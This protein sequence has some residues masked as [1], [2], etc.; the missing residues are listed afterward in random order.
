VSLCSLCDGTGRTKCPSCDGAATFVIERNQ[1]KDNL[2]CRKCEGTGEINCPTC[3]GTGEVLTV[4]TPTGDRAKCVCNACGKPTH[5]DI[6]F[7]E[8]TKALDPA[9]YEE[10]QVLRCR[11]CDAI[12]FRHSH[13]SPMH[14]LPLEDGVFP[15]KEYIFPTRHLIR[16]P[17]DVHWLPPNVRRI[18]REMHLALRSCLRTLTA[19]GIRATIEPYAISKGHRA[20]RSTRR[21]K[22]YAERTY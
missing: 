8:D 20:A 14:G 4:G 19:M 11:G 7:N 18:Y 6:L 17:V 10:Y 12:S 2:S 15:A 22:N 3:S 9:S 16:V 13:R 21:L 5:H 1:G